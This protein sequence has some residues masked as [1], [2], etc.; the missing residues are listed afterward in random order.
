MANQTVIQNGTFGVESIDTKGNC[1]YIEKGKDFSL[2]EVMEDIDTGEIIY[3]IKVLKLGRKE[4]V[5]IP[6]SEATD[7]K[8]V[9]K[10]S[11]SGLDVNGANCSIVPEVFQIKEDS[12]ITAK[13]P[14]GK[15][16][17][18]AGVKKYESK[19]GTR[20]AYAGYYCKK[21]KSQYLGHLDIE[22]KGDADIWFDFAKN[23][24]K[25]SIPLA[26]SLSTAFSAI[27]AAILADEE[28]L[29]NTIV[30]Y[31]GDSSTG[32]TT[33]TVFA[34]S[35]YGPGT[36]R[37]PRGLASTWNAT[38]NAL[39]RRLMRVNGILM[40]MDELSA[41]R[42]KD[43]SGL[44]YS[45]STGVE[46]DR[47]TRSAEVQE[48][49][50][51]RYT[52][53]STGEASLLAKCNG[54]IGLSMRVIEFQDVQWTSSAEE[55]EYIKNVVKNNYGH[56]GTAFGDSLCKWLDK[57][58]LVSLKKE[59]NAMRELYCTN[60]SIQARKERMSSRYALILLA[61]KLANELLGFEMDVKAICDFIIENENVGDDDRDSYANFYEKFV[62]LVTQ[63]RLEHFSFVDPKES[64]KHKSP[65]D[66]HIPNEVWG[67]ITQFAHPLELYTGEFSKETVSMP[68]NIF[69]DLVKNKLGY[70][71]PKM[72]RR[73]LK[74]KKLSVC[75]Q[76]RDTIRRTLNGA[77]MQMVEVYLPTLSELP[78]EFKEKAA[79]EV[80]SAFFEKL[81]HMEKLTAKERSTLINKLKG[82]SPYMTQDNVE[83]L[84]EYIVK[85]KRLHVTELIGLDED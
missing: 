75:E 17:T 25:R 32:K 18:I 56:A 31:V 19:N 49:L 38:K 41:C 85:A 6:K 62:A 71:D 65:P 46:K 34:I 43:F 84:R 72:I 67:T 26:F 22:P 58:G 83:K 59:F 76:D 73:F 42:D 45:I 66:M 14:V 1:I 8:L 3:R 12:Y 30:H 9:L 55:S 80:I 24:T 13:K 39:L 29:D 15:V 60:C 21:L 70:E 54:N 63:H 23:I 52:V 77:R 74:K 37:N 81:D 40:A 51:G 53:M 33:S 68:V 50:V 2:A 28:D 61:A 47:L 27:P 69:D 5:L 11:S 82:V 7:S 16:H 57:Q 20:Y 35:V 4:E 44:V 36:E 79:P 64:N 78:A 48:R 10:Y